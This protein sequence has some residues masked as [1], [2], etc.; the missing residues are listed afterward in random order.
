MKITKKDLEKIINEEISTILEKKDPNAQHGLTGMIYKF[1]LSEKHPDPTETESTEWLK[2]SPFEFR[3]VYI[4]QGSS[5]S[6]EDI[7]VWKYAAGIMVKDMQSRGIKPQDMNIN[8]PVIFAISES[9]TTCGDCAWSLFGWD[10]SEKGE[11]GANLLLPELKLR[12]KKGI[13]PSKRGR[14]TSPWF[15]PIAD[16]GS[17]TEDSEA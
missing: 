10:S 3:D 11:L 8:L 13:D 6:Q 4:E 14:G 17:P 7:A 5:S 12:Y 16:D 1:N 9:I 2:L 15:D